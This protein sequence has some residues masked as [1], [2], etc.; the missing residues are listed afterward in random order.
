MQFL[1]FLLGRSPHLKY[2]SVN[3][4]CRNDCTNCPISSVSNSYWRSQN[5]E[6]IHQLECTEISV[7]CPGENAF[8]LMKYLICNGRKLQLLVVGYSERMWGRERVV[9][10]VRKIKEESG[11]SRVG[12]CYCSRP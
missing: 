5:L 12:L 1:A 11:F 7:C 2:L 4:S 10:R 8:E 6:F 3:Q 9:E